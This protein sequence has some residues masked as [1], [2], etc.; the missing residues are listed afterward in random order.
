MSSIL[1]ILLLTLAQ[2]AAGFGLLTLFRIQLKPALLLPL[3]VLTGIAVFSMVPFLLQLC[4][5]PLT[6]TNVFSS[7]A[8]ACVLLNIRWKRGMAQ[9]RQNSTGPPRVLRMYE[10]PFLLVIALV[11]F[12]SAWRCFYYPP[13]PRD[14]TSGSE[15]IAE[16]A[17]REHTMLN[18]L[19][20]VNLQS[21]NNPFKPPFIISLQLIYKLAG[22]PFGQVWLSVVFTGFIVF[23]YGLLSLTLHRLLTGLL[24]LFFLAIP[25]MYAYTFMA[26]FDYS[27]AVFFFL[28]FYFLQLYFDNLRRGS[29]P[30]EPLLMNNKPHYLA[31]AGL[32]MGIAT[33]IRAETLVL[34]VM[35]LPLIAWQGL[36]G[37]AYF[38]SMPYLSRI[39]ALSKAVLLF[40][41]PT[42]LVYFISIPV[43]INYYLP[44]QYHVPDL[45]NTHLL[46]LAPLF[47]RWTEMNS[48]LIFSK[49]GI[50]LYG[51]F[52]FLFLVLLL[53]ETTVKRRF[54]AAGRNWL[55]AILVVYLGLPLLGWLLPLMD[56][57]NTTKRG[58]FKLF[59]LMLLYLANNELLVNLSDKITKWELKGGS[60]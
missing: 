41:V 52:I 44:V 27:N 48:Q 33:Y 20:S 24:L 19:F 38:K 34:G 57:D 59:P 4:Y 35:M 25:E 60:L 40:I 17:L 5:I 23:L 9:W 39:T 15:V 42:I 55:Y 37:M 16:Y 12:V 6:A 7:L 58:L 21:T 36:K 14:L 10:L 47:K 54:T 26:L 13:F 31:F 43:Y 18:S 28:S 45:V 56:I 32:L 50:E 11:I 53:A 1:S 22:F 29:Y 30:R 49:W 8:I 2:F 46:D 51:Y 3:A